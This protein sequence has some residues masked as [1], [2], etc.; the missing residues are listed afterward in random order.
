MRALTKT[1]KYLFWLPAAGV[2]VL[3]SDTVVLGQD[4]WADG[5]C[6]DYENTQVN[7]NDS[8]R[9][10]DLFQKNILGKYRLLEKMQELADADAL[11]L[12]NELKI[13]ID[14]YH[15]KKIIVLTHIPPFKELCFNRGKPMNPDYLP[16]FVSQATGNV[17][18]DVATKHKDISFLVLCG[19]THERA[20]YQALDNLEARVGRAEYG[21]PAVEMAFML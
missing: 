9:I 8:R 1:E 17:L 5:R 20:A 18:L 12:H 14:N 2:Q 13:A 11:A 15:P 10:D 21:V 19:H 7:L 3:N 6:G 16:Y 4:G